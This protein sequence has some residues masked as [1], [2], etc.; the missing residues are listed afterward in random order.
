MPNH[1]NFQLALNMKRRR[2]TRETSTVTN[3]ADGSYADDIDDDDGDYANTATQRKTKGG[4]RKSRT[5]NVK[6]AGMLKIPPAKRLVDE[7]QSPE[8]RFSLSP[9][10][11]A[12]GGV[13]DVEGTP[14]DLVG[15]PFEDLLEDHLPDMY[16][17]RKRYLESTAETNQWVREPKYAFATQL[18]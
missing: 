9:L 11:D 5:S 7:S 15:V 8:D 2:L 14:E 17:A 6:A 12:I 13:L 1:C 18:L 10:F 16:Q 3:S 4:N